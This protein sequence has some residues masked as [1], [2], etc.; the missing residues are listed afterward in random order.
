[1]TLENRLFLEEAP[2]EV[3]FSPQDANVPRPLGFKF[4]ELLKLTMQGM[5]QFNE[6]QFVWPQP[7]DIDPAIFLQGVKVS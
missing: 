3:G 6:F 5:D 7:G 1:M 4:P 2:L